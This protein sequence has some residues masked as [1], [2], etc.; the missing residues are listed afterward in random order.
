MMRFFYSIRSIV[1]SILFNT[2]NPMYPSSVQEG[3]TIYFMDRNHQPGTMSMLTLMPQTISNGIN[4]KRNPVNNWFKML[5]L[6]LLMTGV[7]QSQLYAQ[8]IA[9]IS[10]SAN[11]STTICSGT[12]VTFTATPT[13]VVAPSYQWY[14]NGNPVGS[15]Q[16]TYTDNALVNS[17]NI[18]C[19]LLTPPGCAGNVTS[20]PISITVTTTP[21]VNSVATQQICHGNSTATI[22]FTGTS[23][24][25]YSWTNNTTSIGLAASGT[26]NIASF[27]TQ[28][29]TTSP[30]T[31][32]I[33]VTPQN[34]ANSITCYG[35]PTSFNI[36]DNPL[37]TVNALAD[38]N[39]CGGGVTNAVSFTGSSVSGTTYTWTNN[40]TSIGL[41]QSNGTASIGAFTTVNNVTNNP[42]IAT[43]VITPTANGCAGASTT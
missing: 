27:A 36:V 25:T 39:I 31:A 3:R 1:N 6:I 11:T 9:T 4:T 15:N 35:T 37:P 21:S 33:V 10:I 18:K 12:N 2:D 14:K 26:G 19:A 8:C 40:Q 5:L 7:S 29:L 38:Q 13:N 43:I 17:D 22:N 42:I 28:N 23:V 32:L 41:A 20:L 30:V 16:N 24:T 34:T